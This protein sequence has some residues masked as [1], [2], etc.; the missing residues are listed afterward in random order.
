[1]PAAAAESVSRCPGGGGDRARRP[2]PGLLTPGALA[3]G[4]DAALD[5]ELAARAAAANAQDVTTIFYTSGTTGLPKGVLSTHDMELRSAYG[6]A[7]ARAFED[8]RRIMFALPLNHV[9]AYVEGLLASMFVAGSVVVQPVF[10]PAGP[11]WPRSSGTR[12]V[13]RCSCPR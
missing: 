1:M 5:G 2:A 3:T 12:S 10:D 13:R 11:R 8:G 7:Y 6:S 4:P 9:F